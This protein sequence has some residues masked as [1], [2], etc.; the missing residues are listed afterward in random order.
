MA[1]LIFDF[2]DELEEACASVEADRARATYRRI[3]AKRQDFGRSP[4]IETTHLEP[5]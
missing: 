3:E 2:E 5:V 1:A 4:A